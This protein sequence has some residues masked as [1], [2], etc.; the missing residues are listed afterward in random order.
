MDH[1]ANQPDI[2]AIVNGDSQE[3]S[4]LVDSYKDLV[5]TIALRMLKNREEAEEVAQDSFIKIFKSL[6]SF[7]GDAK[8]STW[9]YRI[10]YNTCLDRI[11]KYKIDQKSRPI[12]EVTSYHVADM[13]NA[14]DEMMQQE[15]SEMIKKCIQ[16]L[17]PTDAAI[18]TL[19]YFEEQSLIELAKTLKLSANTAKVKLFRA[20]KRLAVILKEQ[21]KPETIKSYE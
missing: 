19:F 16:K 1:I 4:K 10:T 11:K 2:A 6:K 14:L 13:G 15:K 18:L 9:I 17:P 8:L 3:F 7:H 5:F 20:R 21:L 12:E